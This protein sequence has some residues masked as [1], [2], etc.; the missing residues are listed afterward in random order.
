MSDNILLLNIK[1]G[2]DNKIIDTLYEYYLDYETRKFFTSEMNVV[3]KKVFIEEFRKKLTYKYHEFMLIK[4]L[5]DDKIIGFIYSFRYK[6]NDGTLYTTVYISKDYRNKIYGVKAGLIFY[7]FLFEKYTI[8]KIYC[9]I[10]SYNDTMINIAEK[11]GYRLEGKL[12]NHK[13][14][15]GKYYD[16][17]I[18]ALYKEDFYLMLKKLTKESS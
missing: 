14:Y 17:F 16:M 8:R 5:K 18:Y 13:Y 12:L 11:G 7:K 3:S 6:P 10:Y 1:D 15:N 9:C 2:V 4:N